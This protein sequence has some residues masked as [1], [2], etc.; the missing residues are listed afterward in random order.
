MFVMLFHICDSTIYGLGLKVLTTDLGGVP[1]IYNILYI[2]YIYHT[3]YIYIYYISIIYILYIYIIHIYYTYIL[4]IYII[5]IYY[6]Y[7]LYIYIYTYILYIYY[8]Y[9]YLYIY[10]Y[11]YTKITYVCV[12]VI[13]CVSAGFCRHLD[14][15][16]YF[17]HMFRLNLYILRISHQYC[18]CP[19]RQTSPPLLVAFLLTSKRATVHVVVSWWS[20]DFFT[21]PCQLLFVMVAANCKT[22]MKSFFG[23]GKSLF[24]LQ[25]RRIGEMGHRG[26]VFF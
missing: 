15:R 3:Y 16:D 1:Y 2:L 22:L 11:I 6:T 18:W 5:H 25:H 10:N 20:N 4:Y 24:I 13:V 19:L 7:I 17:L 21:W 9:T 12:C 8:I 26:I 14:S 23:G